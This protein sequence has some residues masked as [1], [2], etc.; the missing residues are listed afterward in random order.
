MLEIS[1]Q[2]L[3]LRAQCKLL[4]INRSSVYYRSL[5]NDDSE[6][7]NLIKEIY[8]ESDCR[9]GY[10]KITAGLKGRNCV[11]NHKKVLKIMQD[12]GIQGLYPRKFVKTTIKANHA[13]FPYLLT[14]LQITAPNQVWATDI[15]Y[16][17]MPG[18]F[19]YFAAI[20]RPWGA[21]GPPTHL[22]S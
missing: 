14:D 22:T 16:I 19:M 2:D 9:Y 3:S 10:R 20:I 8:L 15:T 21:A 1:N 5:I 18:R 7:A 6:L 12:M 11:V 4:G 17:S 13:V